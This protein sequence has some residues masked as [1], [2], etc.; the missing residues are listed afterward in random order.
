MPLT[1]FVTPLTPL[2]PLIP[3]VRRAA[4]APLHP[5]PATPTPL[6]PVQPLVPFVVPRLP[7]R[8]CC[9]S[10]PVRDRSPVRSVA[11]QGM[12]I[13]AEDVAALE[14]MLLDSGESLL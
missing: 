4:D 11:G 12:A 8:P 1:P 13:T 3:F 6:I 10:A 9:R 14:Q 5:V 7:I 2:T